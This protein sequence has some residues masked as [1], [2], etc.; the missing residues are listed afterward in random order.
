MN[1]NLVDDIFQWMRPEPEQ[2]KLTENYVSVPPALLITDAGN[3]VWTIGFNIGPK[4]KTPTGEYAWN[5][6][7]NGYEVGELASRIEMCGNRIRI[8][9]KAGWKRWTGRDFV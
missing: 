6:L 9:T 8:F 5:V 4:D 3:N 1:Q 7:R 2:L